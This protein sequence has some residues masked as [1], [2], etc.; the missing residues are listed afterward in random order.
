MNLT[1]YYYQFPSALTPKF[2][3]DIVEYGKS[4]TPEMAVTGGGSK[5]DEKNV[6]K[7]V[8]HQF[9]SEILLSENR[10][11]GCFDRAMAWT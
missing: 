2:V 3:D 7:K 5:D 1:N 9:S 8:R 6:D 10:Q 11:T 4:H